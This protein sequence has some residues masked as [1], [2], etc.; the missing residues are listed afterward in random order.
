[1]SGFDDK[2]VSNGDGGLTSHEPVRDCSH[3]P[4]VLMVS[5]VFLLVAVVVL[6]TAYIWRLEETLDGQRDINY[7]ESLQGSG[8]NV[9]RDATA[10]VDPS[11]AQSPMQRHAHM[12]SQSGEHEAAATP[13]D[14]HC[15]DILDRQE[16]LNRLFARAVEQMRGSGGF[17]GYRTSGSVNVRC[18]MSE[19]PDRYVVQMIIPGAEQA[20]ISVFIEGGV[21][22]VSGTHNGV[23]KR[24][25]GG[26]TY[27]QRM[28]GRFLQT[29]PLP[30]PVYADK[31]TLD[32]SDN[33]LTLEIPKQTS[34]P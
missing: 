15:Q 33:L 21:L 32:V 24:N 26:Q 19:F 11:A 2:S 14:P 18:S 13:V 4:N 1:M 10:P 17:I 34:T 7:V 8:R 6:Q 9:N 16:Q 3:R 20:A 31:T 5:A 23:V 22:K 29:V 25:E 28:S 27:Q 12:V 30:G